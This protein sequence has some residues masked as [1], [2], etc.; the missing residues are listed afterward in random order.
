MCAITIV[1][2]VLKEAEELRLTAHMI[3]NGSFE[4]SC[5]VDCKRFNSPSLHLLDPAS[6][7]LSTSVS[8]FA[9]PLNANDHL[10]VNPGGK[11]RLKFTKPLPW[12]PEVIFFRL[13]EEENARRIEAKR[14]EVKNNLWSREY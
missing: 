14:R 1:G 5:G 3:G 8:V 9:S 10:K 12:V 13:E 11:N 7:A 4:N 6:L 2:T